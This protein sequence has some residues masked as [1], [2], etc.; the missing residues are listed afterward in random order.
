MLQ[1]ITGNGVPYNEVS[2]QWGKVYRRHTSP[3]QESYVGVAV[4]R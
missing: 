4:G 3:Q 2:V 1:N